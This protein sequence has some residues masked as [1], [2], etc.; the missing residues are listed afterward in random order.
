VQAHEAL[1]VCPPRFQVGPVRK[2]MVVGALSRIKGY[3]VVLGLLASTGWRASGA[4][5]SLL[6]YS[7]DD[8]ALLQAGAQVLGRYD[9]AALVDRLVAE[10]PDLVWLPSI[11]PETYNYVLS[12]ALQAGCRVAVF[13][14]GAPA[15]RLR[16]QPLHGRILPLALASEPE[17][18]AAALL[19]SPADQG[20]RPG[21]LPH[22]YTSASGSVASS[23]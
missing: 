8:E 17:A 4:Q 9:D 1:Q 10:A 6:G 11:W 22:S 18:L 12:A 23:S 7:L 3:D 5:L 20:R 15:R 13:D 2:L 14:I 21:G 16:E 19:L